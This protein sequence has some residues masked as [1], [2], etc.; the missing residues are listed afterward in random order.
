MK[1]KLACVV[2][3]AMIVFGLSGCDKEQNSFIDLC[4]NSIKDQLRSPSGYKRIDLSYQKN[5]LSPDQYI[6]KRK[7]QKESAELSQI[8]I[9][10]LRDGSRKPVLFVANISY[11]APNAFGTLVRNSATCDYL[12]KDGGL[13]QATK[14]DVR[15]NGKNFYDRVDDFVDYAKKRYLKDQDG[16]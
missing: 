5:Y 2:G 14:E 7:Q 1:N 8:Q 15:I 9:E 3:V 6:L 12:S 11:D 4:E 16:N 10:A 13:D